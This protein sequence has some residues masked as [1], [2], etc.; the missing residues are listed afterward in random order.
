MLWHHVSSTSS[1][2]RNN[3]VTD[4][5]LKETEHARERKKYR[6]CRPLQML[7]VDNVSAAPL[8]RQDC[9]SHFAFVMQLWC[10]VTLMGLVGDLPP[11]EF[12]SGQVMQTLQ[13]IRD[14]AGHT[15]SGL[16][17]NAINS[18][19]AFPPLLATTVAIAIRLVKEVRP[20]PCMREPGV[21]TRNTNAYS[22]MNL[23]QRPQC[24]RLS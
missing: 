15:N 7:T 23:N 20:L 2:Y 9:Y 8:T 22:Y 11:A 19:P 6:N 12:W 1:S 10:F 5:S 4:L 14:L 17:S 13:Q 21:S 16:I 24:P 3:A 18:S